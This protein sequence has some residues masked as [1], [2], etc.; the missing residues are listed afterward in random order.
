MKWDCVA[1]PLSRMSKS[2]IICGISH[3]YTSLVRG[4]LP[5]MR[6]VDKVSGPV[7][8]LYQRTEFATVSDIAGVS[9]LY[10]RTKSAI[11]SAKLVSVSAISGSDEGAKAVL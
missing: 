5:W 6:S 11:A 3:Y 8:E 2:S 7:S 9:E 4:M 10:Q 1:F